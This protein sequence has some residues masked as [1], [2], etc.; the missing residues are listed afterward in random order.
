MSAI[1]TLIDQVKSSAEKIDEAQIEI[2]LDKVGASFIRG[3]EVIA[4]LLI[5]LFVYGMVGEQEFQEATKWTQSN[6]GKR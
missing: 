6:T 1:Q 3:L 5:V 4:I 2:D